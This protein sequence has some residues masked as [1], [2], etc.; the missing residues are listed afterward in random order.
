MNGVELN[1]QRESLNVVNV[2]RLGE[3]VWD[4]KNLVVGNRDN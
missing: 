4:Y 3:T 2:I 1:N